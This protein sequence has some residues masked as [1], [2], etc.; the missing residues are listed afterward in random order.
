MKF[1]LFLLQCIPYI[2]AIKYNFYIILYNSTFFMFIPR[3]PHRILNAKMQIYKKSRKP[4]F[5]SLAVHNEFNDVLQIDHL[6]GYCHT[7]TG[8]ERALIYWLLRR[9]LTCKERGSYL[10]LVGTQILFFFIIDFLH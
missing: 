3:N 1:E 4:S 6:Y 8:M 10:I 9:E 5:P 2:S 7:S